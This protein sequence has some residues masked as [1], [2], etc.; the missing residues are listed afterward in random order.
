M[1][2]EKQREEALRTVPAL[3][4]APDYIDLY[5][6]LV[7]GDRCFLTQDLIKNGRP[8]AVLINKKSREL[9]LLLGRHIIESEIDV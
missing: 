4:K 1:I 3:V 2:T 9:A 8:S 7:Y 6:Y 5:L